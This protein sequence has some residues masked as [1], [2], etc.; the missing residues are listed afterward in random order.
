MKVTH[1][2][3]GYTLE[4]EIEKDSGDEEE[5]DMLMTNYGEIIASYIVRKSGDLLKLVGDD[6]VFQKNSI[7][8]FCLINFVVAFVVY[9]LPFIYYM[10]DFYCKDEKGL[11][12]KCS[13]HVACNNK[14]GFDVKIERIS[15]NSEFNLYC[16]RR[17]LET[18]GM[19]IIFLFSGVITLFLSILSDHIGRIPILFIGWITTT[20]GC[21]LSYLSNEY[22]YIVFG[23]ALSMLGVDLYASIMFVY[24]NEITG[25][26]IRSEY[27]K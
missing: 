19:S 12:Y 3:N 23:V 25:K 20:T 16:D 24:N 13:E 9:E 14:Y 22:L 27:K 5:S 2:E 4:L 26:L 17:S 6:G 15:L 10:P 8:I 7:F 11:S 1:E 18:E 21:L